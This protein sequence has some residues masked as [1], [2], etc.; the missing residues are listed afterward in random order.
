MLG[1][2]LVA[3]KKKQIGKQLDYIMVSTRWKSCV[4]SCEPKWGPSMHRNVHGHKG[5]HALL[6]CTWKWRIRTEKKKPTKDFSCLQGSTP[7]DA[8][9]RQKFDE[10]VHLRLDQLQYDVFADSATDMYDKM[11]GAIHH[12]VE[13]VIPTVKRVKGIKRKVSEKTKALF[14][15]RTEMAGTKAQYKKIQKEIKDSSMQDFHDWVAEW[16]GTMQAANGVGNTSKIFEGVKAL[17][18]K[19]ERPPCNLSRMHKAPRWTMPQR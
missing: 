16:A 2:L 17:R 14:K 1:K 13:T 6:S 8:A 7:E 11:C 10:A 18:G 15:K 12:A 5:D 3:T 19:R 4:R 9:L